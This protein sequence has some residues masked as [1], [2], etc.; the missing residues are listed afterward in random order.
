MMFTSFSASATS[1]EERPARP[2]Q[3]LG[4]L[5]FFEDTFSPS[6]DSLYPE[7]AFRQIVNDPFEPSGDVRNTFV[8]REPLAARAA[9]VLVEA[10][11]RLGLSKSS[12]SRICG[13]ARQTIYDWI[14]K[15]HE[16]GE[17]NLSK[18]ELLDNLISYP[19]LRGH[20]LSRKWAKRQT[21]KGVSLL[22]V[23]ERS[24]PDHAL[25]TEVLDELIFLIEKDRSTE[26]PT[27]TGRARAGW[28]PLNEAQR[29]RNLAY[30]LSF[31]PEE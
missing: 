1:A 19:R 26:Q 9:E 28:P 2:Q 10:Q 21:V 24:T 13:V 3:D 14:N 15:A 20:A 22:A 23:L 8:I 31:K 18:L 16:P 7:G 27:Q 11:A 4:M 5:L 29:E 6:S 25:A 30:N 17:E 12:L